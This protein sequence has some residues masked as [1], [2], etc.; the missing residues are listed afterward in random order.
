[1]AFTDVALVDV[2]ATS[3][4]LKR[5][6]VA[7]PKFVPEIVTAVPTG[8]DDGENPDTVGTPTGRRSFPEPN[9]FPCPA[10]PGP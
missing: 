3:T 10:L 9:E 2:G 4:P 6:V 1:M 8:P 7:P 5:T